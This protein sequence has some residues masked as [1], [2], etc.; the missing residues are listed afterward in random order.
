MSFETE[1]AKNDFEN[2]R[3]LF[4]CPQSEA[5]KTQTYLVTSA[6]QWLPNYSM[7]FK[8]AFQIN[9]II[10]RCGFA[11]EVLIGKN[12]RVIALKIDNVIQSDFSF[13][14]KQPTNSR[15]LIKIKRL[16]HISLAG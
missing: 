5:E 6:S 14:F 8:F 1:T 3:K 12:M 2:S 7:H 4:L 11:K 13:L 9:K 16:I 10:A 15:I